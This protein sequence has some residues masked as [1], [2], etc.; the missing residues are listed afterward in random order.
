MKSLI[1][2]F[3]FL[4]LSLCSTSGFELDVSTKYHDPNAVV[5]TELKLEAETRAGP[6]VKTVVLYA[7]MYDDGFDKVKDGQKPIWEPETGFKSDYVKV[8]YK[9]LAPEALKVGLLDKNTLTY[10]AEDHYARFYLKKDQDWA[11]VDADEY[12]EFLEKNEYKNLVHKEFEKD[13][14]FEKPDDECIIQVGRKYTPDEVQAFKKLSDSK[15][16][17]KVDPLVKPS[18][19]EDTNLRRRQGGSDSSPAPTEPGSPDKKGSSFLT[20]SLLLP[21]V[22]LSC[23]LFN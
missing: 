11:K 21:I 1:F 20:A 23:T 9:G 3:L 19:S 13:E 2:G 17:V 4:K 10:N 5:T 7:S 22:L 15:G 18:E 12:F 8:F 6:S 16:L 14:K